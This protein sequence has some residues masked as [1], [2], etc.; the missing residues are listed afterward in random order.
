MS[1]RT[2]PAAR[3]LQGGV[4]V[5]NYASHFNTSRSTDAWVSFDTTFATPGSH[6]TSLTVNFTFNT[7]ET[8]QTVESHNTTQ[9]HQTLATI[10]TN[11]LTPVGGGEQDLTE[12]NT[13]ATID[14]VDTVNTSSTFNTSTTFETVGQTVLVFSTDDTHNTSR[15]TGYTSNFS[16][17]FD[18][19]SNTFRDTT[20]W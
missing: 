8:H 3:L 5:T 10:V 2:S 7:S 18:T 13:L 6:N 4:H 14:T 12:V 9:T 20:W 17:V 19:F 15:P 11:R 16:T 1:F